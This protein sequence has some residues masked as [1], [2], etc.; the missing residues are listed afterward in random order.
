M[1]L[2]EHQ[3]FK[4][5]HVLGILLT[6]C[7]CGC[8]GRSFGW[9][10]FFC[11]GSGCHGIF[12]LGWFVNPVIYGPPR[13]SHAGMNLNVGKRPKGRRNRQKLPPEVAMI[14]KSTLRNG[15]RFESLQKWQALQGRSARLSKGASRSSPGPDHA[16][17]HA[18]RARHSTVTLLARLR[19]LSTSVPARHRRVIGQQLQRHHMQQ[20]A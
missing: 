7:R 5:R 16:A 9:G 15:A 13:A 1:A 19:G 14:K 10:C 11:G 12:P 20:R 3:F 8:T 17:R 4:Q 2:H 18:R 6:P